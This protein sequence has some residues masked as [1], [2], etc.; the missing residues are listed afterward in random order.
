MSKCPLCH[1]SVRDDFGLIECAGCGAQLIVHMDGRV[2]YQGAQD[3]GGMDE[4]EVMVQPELEPSGAFS[5]E[6]MREIEFGDEDL[7]NPKVDSVVANEPTRFDDELSEN[8]AEEEPPQEAEPEKEFIGEPFPD[9]ED[10]ANEAPP[11]PA[12]NAAPSSDSSDLGDIAAF[13]NSDLS[14]GREGSLRYNLLI[15]GIDTQDVRE[16]FRE[17]ITDRKFMWDSDQILRSIRNGAVRIPNITPTKAYI[18]IARLRGV[19]LQIR[20][21]QYALSQT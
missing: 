7:G 2:E 11:P 5:A 12:Y 10:Q 16:A 21:E 9:F 20:W 13:G 4:E 17:A 18:L 19:P 15:E 14:G 3:L 6:P 1:A 8:L